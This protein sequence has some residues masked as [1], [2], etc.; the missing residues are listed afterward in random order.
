MSL[1]WLSMWTTIVNYYKVSFWTQTIKCQGW[2]WVFGT[3]DWADR[4][5]GGPEQLAVLLL[6]L[7]THIITVFITANFKRV[8]YLIV[9]LII[10]ATLTTLLYNFEVSWFSHWFWLLRCLI[11]FEFSKR[12]HN[13]E[14]AKKNTSISPINSCQSKLTPFWDERRGSIPRDLSMNTWCWE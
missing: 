4:A 5:G 7:I 10:L 1:V 11:M 2:S 12:S 3:F 6:D 9:K 13:R 14:D 8:W